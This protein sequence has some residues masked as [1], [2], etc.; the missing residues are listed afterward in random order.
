LWNRESVLSATRY[1]VDEQGEEMAVYE[2]QPLPAV[3]AR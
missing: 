1:V 2:A 3:T